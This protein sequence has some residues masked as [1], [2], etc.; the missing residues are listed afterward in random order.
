MIIAVSFPSGMPVVFIHMWA[1]F[2][3]GVTNIVNSVT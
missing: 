1:V 2:Q 3:T